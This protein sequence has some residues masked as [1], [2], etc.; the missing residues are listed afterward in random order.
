MKIAYVDTSCLVAIAFDEASAGRIGSRLQRFDRLL[1]SNLLEAE[2]RSALAREGVAEGAEILLADMTWVYP[3]RPLTPEF[4]RITRSGHAKGADLWH[5]ACALF[6]APEGKD[7]AFM[8]LDERQREL[9]LRL[10]FPA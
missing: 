4:Q 5:L 10:G 1:A 9:A 8:T 2:L 7:L 6:V 3:N